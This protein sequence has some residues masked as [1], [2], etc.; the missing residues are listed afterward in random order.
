MA[1]LGIFTIFAVSEVEAMV[2][3]FL[4]EKCAKFFGKQQDAKANQDS[5][6]GRYVQNVPKVCSKDVQN[7]KKIINNFCENK[8]IKKTS[9]IVKS[10]PFIFLPLSGIVATLFYRPL[11]RISKAGFNVVP[12]W[13]KVPAGIILVQAAYKTYKDTHKEKSN[14]TN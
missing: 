14:N 3:S 13:V 12:L 8:L 5:V 11:W 4:K 1:V 10:H 2:F 7:L 9:S 6:L